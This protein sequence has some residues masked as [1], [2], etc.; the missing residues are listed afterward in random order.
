MIIAAVLFFISLSHFD[1]AVR[2]IYEK[3]REWWKDF[4][5][6]VGFF[7]VPP[8]EGWFDGSLMRQRLMTML[9][10]SIPKELRSDPALV[11]AIF[12][13]RLF[14]IISSVAVL[15]MILTAAILGPFG[16]VQ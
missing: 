12:S 11:S 13:Y 5:R 1:R 10:F 14:S 8:G 6:P 3:H 15:G 9:T 2:I 16:I 7:W 4:G